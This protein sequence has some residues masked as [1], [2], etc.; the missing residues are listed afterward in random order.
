MNKDMTIVEI[1]K[2]FQLFGA[3]LHQLEKPEKFVADCDN[4]GRLMNLGFELW[5]SRQ[6]SACKP[7]ENHFLVTPCT[8]LADLPVSGNLNDADITIYGRENN[9]W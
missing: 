2:A 6:P 3:L 5:M 8:K 1:S 4:I 7:T 9:K